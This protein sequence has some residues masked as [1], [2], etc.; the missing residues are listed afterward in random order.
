MCTPEWSG[1]EAGEGLTQWKWEHVASAEHDEQDPR[2]SAPL[3]Q[4][5]KISVR[6]QGGLGAWF[7]LSFF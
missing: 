6:S 4:S 7:Y 3:G 2:L 5:R 1:R